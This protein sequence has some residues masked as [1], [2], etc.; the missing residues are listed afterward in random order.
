M[1]SQKLSTLHEA[2]HASEI[3]PDVALDRL[4]RIRAC[5]SASSVTPCSGV[6]HGT[7]PS[8]WVGLD[9]RRRVV[10]L[11]QLQTDALV[12]LDA[13]LARRVEEIVSTA[14]IEALRTA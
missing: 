2:V 10:A 11:T 5:R 6:G 1:R 4:T 9:L 3:P 14:T 13:G 7:S 12:T 8:S